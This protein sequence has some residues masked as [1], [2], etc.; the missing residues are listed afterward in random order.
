MGDLEDLRK[1]RTIK[2]EVR[3]WTNGKGQTEKVA[4]FQGRSKHWTHTAGYDDYVIVEE[5]T[6][7]RDFELIHNRYP[8]LKKC[9]NL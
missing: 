8:T 6:G 9:L 2:I 3:E 5:W 7:V 1:N 4:W